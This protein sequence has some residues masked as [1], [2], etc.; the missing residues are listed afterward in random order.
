MNQYAAS[1]AIT[2][3]TAGLRS[4]VQPERI[5]SWIAGNSSTHENHLPDLYTQVEREQRQR[6]IGAR[7]LRIFAQHV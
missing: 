7:Q 3:D 2:A 4:L 6:Q 5:K 1:S